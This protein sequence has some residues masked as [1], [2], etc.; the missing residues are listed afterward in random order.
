MGP[1][2]AKCPHCGAPEGHIGNICPSVSEVVPCPT[3]KG[4][5][6][7]RRPKRSA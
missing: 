6:R 5:G 4:Y 3:C 2:K 7:I 1:K